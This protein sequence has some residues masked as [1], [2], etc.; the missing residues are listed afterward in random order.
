MFRD[1]G[2]S[3]VDPA[4]GEGSYG[5]RDHQISSVI[6][7]FTGVLLV[8]VLLLLPAG[9][10]LFFCNGP[11]TSSQRKFILFYAGATAE[12]TQHCSNAHQPQM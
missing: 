9:M 8:R 12:P 2:I 11:S 7:T 5:C 10:C 1:T 3:L 4:G 6:S